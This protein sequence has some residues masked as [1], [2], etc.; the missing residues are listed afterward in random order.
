MWVI[1][2]ILLAW[3]VV[4]LQEICKQL[5]CPYWISLS[6]KLLIVVHSEYFL[7]FPC[8]LAKSQCFAGLK[9]H[10]TKKIW[11]HLWLIWVAYQ[12]YLIHRVSTSYL[13]FPASPTRRVPHTY[14]LHEISVIVSSQHND[15]KNL[16]NAS[17]SILCSLMIGLWCSHLFILCLCFNQICNIRLVEVDRRQLYSRFFHAVCG[18]FVNERPDGSLECSLCCCIC[19]NQLVRGFH[20]Q[21]H[22]QDESATVSAWCAGQTATELLQISPN[23]FFELPEVT[24]AKVIKFILSFLKIKNIVSFTLLWST[25]I[26]KWAG[27]QSIPLCIYFLYLSSHHFH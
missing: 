11:R 5:V 13:F 26:T 23:E 10:G 4:W 12:R 17:Y 15:K 16:S 7:R 25:W 19:N 8:Y 27:A 21:V 2:F 6:P 18:H 20:L 22:L 14:G 9:F 3:Y 24:H 1:L